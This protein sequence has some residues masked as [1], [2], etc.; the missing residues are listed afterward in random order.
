[1]SN[2]LFDGNNQFLYSIYGNSN[3]QPSRHNPS[4][5]SS[6][7]QLHIYRLRP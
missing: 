1:M 2:P 7:V 3:H 5:K 6:T 4:V